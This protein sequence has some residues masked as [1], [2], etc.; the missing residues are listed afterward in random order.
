ML[1]LIL[2]IIHTIGE[3]HW[4]YKPVFFAGRPR[5]DF[6]NR[7]FPDGNI[8]LNAH[9][10]GNSY[11]VNDGRKS[12]PS[13]H[14]SVA[15]ASFGFLAFYLAAKLKVFAT[16]GKASTGKL[17]AFLCPLMFALCVAISRT[18]DY[19]HHWQGESNRMFILTCIDAPIAPYANMLLILL[20]VREAFCPR[21]RHQTPTSLHYNTILL[22]L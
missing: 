5:P 16:E 14:S 22:M 6:L 13:G 9:C 11:L 7:C 2:L 10:S 4:L 1:N 17:L 19:H 12:F 20:R 8:V 3:V 21:R 18:C 15:F